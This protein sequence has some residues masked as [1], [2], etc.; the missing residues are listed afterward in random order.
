LV[1]ARLNTYF[2]V[3]AGSLLLIEKTTGDLH[4]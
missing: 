2:N 1:V 3:E 4:L